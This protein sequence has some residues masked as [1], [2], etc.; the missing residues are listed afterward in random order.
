MSDVD[1]TR[2]CPFYRFQG[3]IHLLPFPVARGHL[4]SLACSP[5]LHLHSHHGAF[6]CLLPW[7]HLS[8]PFLPPFCIFK[9]PYDDAK[10][11]QVIQDDLLIL[12]P[13]LSSLNSICHLN[14]FSLC[15]TPYS[16]IPGHE[17]CGGVLL[18]STIP[19]QHFWRELSHKERNPAR[20]LLTDPWS[21]LPTFWKERLL[22][23]LHL[24]SMEGWSTQ[25]LSPHLYLT[26]T[27]NRKSKCVRH[28]LFNFKVLS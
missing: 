13:G 18:L 25:C 14:S 21:P 20:C 22:K 28:C 26:F 10:A 5:F 11:T 7:S 9:G 8:S 27:K 23:S 12:R 2:L 17:Q 6:V 3:R 16:Q 4:H 15:N 24:L 19:T 1:V